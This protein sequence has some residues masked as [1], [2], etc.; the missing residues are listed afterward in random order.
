MADLIS[1]AV[2]AAVQNRNKRVRKKLGG[3]AGGDDGAFYVHDEDAEVVNINA[4]HKISGQRTEGITTTKQMI[5][6]GRKVS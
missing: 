4:M 2:A 1:G 3:E 6:A 5:D